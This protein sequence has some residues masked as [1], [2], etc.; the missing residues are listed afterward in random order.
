M[1]AALK[2]LV[3]TPAAAETAAAAAAAGQD[4]VEQDSSLPL[5]ITLG[6]VKL[7]Y[8]AGEKRWR[9]D[10][11]EMFQAAEELH[12]LLDENEDMSRRL[13]EA[14]R[15]ASVE[16]EGKE[17]ALLD[18]LAERQKNSRL[19]LELRNAQQDLDKAFETI[20][21]LKRHL[22]DPNAR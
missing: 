13:E 14:R 19:E 9:S 16:R 4:E 5:S 2:S 11:S 17:K 1:L 15:E 10:T 8:D 18:L 3:G 20:A 22:L 12:R 6:G 21:T 7:V